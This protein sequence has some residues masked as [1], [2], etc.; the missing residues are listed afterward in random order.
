MC[1]YIYIL[2]IYI[3]VYTHIVIVIVIVVILM[4]IVIVVMIIGA[5]GV[6]LTAE[7]GELCH[8]HVLWAREAGDVKTW[9][10]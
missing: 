5:E 1:V 4:I 9:L 7:E 3:Y 2:Y 6:C 8:H 10:E